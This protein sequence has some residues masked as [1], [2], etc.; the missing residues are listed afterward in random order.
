M[1]TRRPRIAG[2]ENSAM[3]SGTRLE[4]LPTPIPLMVRPTYIKSKFP[5][6]HVCMKLPARN[7]V[8][9]MM[10]GIR[11]PKRSASGRV[12]RAPKKQ[13]P[14]KTLTTFDDI[15]LA[16]VVESPVMPNAF[17]NDASEMVDPGKKDVYQL[18]AFRTVN[19]PPTYYT[20]IIS[21]CHGTETGHEGIKICS[22]V[23]HLL[24]SRSVLY[25]R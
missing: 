22:K 25:N 10:R 16:A 1:P 15:L 24:W 11:R 9:V 3:Y 7:M 17:L 6:A 13:P 19:I 8:P 12:K 2:G 18:S 14:W 21:E 5:F 20:A 23:V 4:A